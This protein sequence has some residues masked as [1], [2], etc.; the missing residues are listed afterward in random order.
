[1]STLFLI[2]LLSVNEDS[3]TFLMVGV[4]NLAMLLGWIGLARRVGLAARRW[5]GKAKGL[6]T[7]V[8]RFPSLYSLWEE[9]ARDAT[10]AWIAA[11]FVLSALTVFWFGLLAYMVWIRYLVH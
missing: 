5:S 9:S 8:L 1:M 7:E 3:P 4:L 11:G 10:P 2:E 6:E